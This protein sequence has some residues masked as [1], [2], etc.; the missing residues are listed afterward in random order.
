MA[1]IVSIAVQK[2]PQSLQEFEKLNPADLGV[3]DEFVLDSTYDFT[4]NN[5]ELHLY[6]LQD[7][8]I[9]SI[10]NYPFAKK[11]TTSESDTE[12]TSVLTL[13]PVEDSKQLGYEGKDVKL[14]YHFLDD[15]FSSNDS[16]SEFF[17]E[18]ISRDRRE[19]FA[20]SRQLTEEDIINYVRALQQLIND[21]IYFFDFRLNFGNNDLFI[22]LNLDVY[23]SRG[24]VGIRIK[25]YEP[26]PKSYGVRDKFTVQE[27]VSDSIL[28]EVGTEVDESLD[29]TLDYRTRLLERDRLGIYSDDELLRFNNKPNFDIRFSLDFNNSF[30]DGGTF[31]SGYFNLGDLEDIEVTGSYYEAWSNLGKKGIDLNI[32]YTDFSN[33][34]HFGSAEERIRNFKYKLDQIH[35]FEESMEA[36]KTGSLNSSAISGSINYYQNQLKNIFINF[37]H[38]D[39]HL[40]FESG[41]TAWPKSTLAK[42]HTNLISSTPESVNFYNG[43][44]SSGSTYDATNIDILTNFIP[45]FLREDPSNENVLTYTH[46]LGHHFDNLWI[47]ANAV[48][49]KYDNDNRLNNGIS[50]ELAADILRNFGV[51]IFNSSDATKDFYKLYTSNFYDS[52]SLN[53]TVNVLAK[54]SDVDQAKLSLAYNDYQ[55]EIYKRIYHNLP[56]LLKSK[57]TIKALRA[58]ILSFGVPTDLLEIR[59]Y[60][61]DDTSIGQHFGLEES[62]TDERSRIR[63]E[64]D[65]LIIPGS[66]LSNTRSVRRKSERYHKDDNKIEIGMSLN[67][68]FD[69]FIKDSVGEEWTIDDYI[70]DYSSKRVGVYTSLDNLREGL[71]SNLS[72][73]N[74]KDFTRLIKFYDTTLFKAAKEYIPARASIETGIIIKPDLLDRSL[75]KSP[76]FTGTYPIYTGSISIATTTGSSGGT[77]TQAQERSTAYNTSIKTPYG[78]AEKRDTLYETAK[79]TGELSGSTFGV[80]NGELNI[81][82]T[83]K[84]PD[85]IPFKFAYSFISSSDEV[86][87]ISGSVPTPPTPP[88]PPAFIIT[89]DTTATPT[90]NPVQGSITVNAQPVSMSLVVNGGTGGGAFTSASLEIGFAGL[91]F[92]SYA[93]VT[94]SASSGNVETYSTTINLDGNYIFRV[95]ITDRQGT[96]LNKANISGSI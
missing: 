24:R 94:G 30:P 14:L 52:G 69:T 84:K 82:N 70:G 65:R 11:L 23:E 56:L 66:P 31:S 91:D 87:F 8:R 22:C 21:D 93:T 59:Q 96:I 51:R 85:R 6:T 44:L 15:L 45:A 75:I 89:G 26:L 29:V 95:T 77:Y 2:N 80:S 55:G 37:D 9:E 73:F 92:D 19:I 76:L 1:R 78:L 63:L 12:I 86:T 74:V 5:I 17:I 60:G 27:K 18:N 38:Y 72:P 83:F 20:L 46:M 3:V 35:S 39:R 81:A 57:G 64:D 90:K 47:Y 42:P 41:S 48:T 49:D 28:F 79:F 40:F 50:R 16:S 43:L 7:E 33:F 68:S 10:Y 25:L 4:S 53:E 88:P 62:S 32:D 54:P 58:L 61:G 34:V 13:N 67:G 36:L 71:L